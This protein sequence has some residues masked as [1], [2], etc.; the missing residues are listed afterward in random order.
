MSY[1]RLYDLEL[2]IRY[3]IP[4]NYKEQIGCCEY[5]SAWEILDELIRERNLLKW[6][7][8]ANESQRSMDQHQQGSR[9]A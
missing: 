7:L 5:R 1:K 2:Q 8:F 4:A 6:E 3:G 9:S